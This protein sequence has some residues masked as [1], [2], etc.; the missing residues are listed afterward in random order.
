MVMQPGNNYQL[1]IE[2]I[3]LFIRRYY[4]NKL[5][6]GVILWAAVLL[7]GY[8]VAT[9]S[10]YFGHFTTFSRTVIFYSFIALNLA[11]IS[12]Y[13]LP[14]VFALLRLKE[15]ISHHQA[16]EI[17]G[18]HFGEIQD[19]LLNTLQLKEIADRD[20]RHAQLIQASIDQKIEVLRPV[21]FPTAVD[22]RQNVKYLKWVIPPALLILIIA[23]AAPKIL[24]DGT[25]RLVK[26]NQYFA[27][28]APFQFIIT[29][30]SLQATQ[31][32]DFK[33]D[34]K[35]QGNNFP[36]A[37]YIETE[38]H[39]FKLDKLS[40]SRFTYLFTNVQHTLAFKL[41]GGGYS[42]STYKLVVNAKP[43]LLH[44]NAALTYPAYLHKKN[45]VITNAGDLTIPVGTLVQ[46][47]LH[48]EHADQVIFKLNQQQKLLKPSQQDVFT[49]TERILNSG[50]YLLKPLNK[51]VINS[52]SAAYAIH[53]IADESPAIVAEEKQD[54]VS[55]KALYFNGKI[56]D[57]HGFSSLRF[58]YTVY[59]GDKKAGSY[60]MPVKADLTSTAA[61][62]F[63]FWNLK[64]LKAKPGNRISYYF[65]VVDNDAV[66]GPKTA[67]TNEKSLD[68]PTNQQIA[69]ELNAGTKEVQQKMQSAAKMAAKLEKETQ[70]LNQN[71]LNKRE[72]SFDEKK[73]VEDLL[74]KRKDLEEMLKNIRD[75]N[76]KNIY[77]RQQTQQQ[78]EQVTQLQKQ[79]DELLKN[80]LDPKTREMLERLKELL[81]TEQKTGT[82]EELNQM[83]NEN[84]SMK[85]ELER[86]AELYKKLDFEQK[87][88]QNVNK[89]NELA[90]K[91]QQLAEKSKQSD[92]A[93]R[94]QLN[95]QQQQLNKDFQEVKKG[96]N[97]LEKLAKENEQSQFSNPQQEE[98]QI[99]QKMNESAEQ[100]SKNN[101]KKAAQS[102]QQAAEAMQQLGRKL[103]QDNQ[104]QEGQQLSLNAQQLRELIKNLVNSSFDQ[105]KLMQTFRNTSPSD[106]NYT[107]LS[108]KQKDIKDNLKTAEDSLY[109]LSKKVPQIQS[110]VNDE[111][112]AINT[113]ISK[114]IDYLGDRRTMEA[115]RSQQYAMTS[116]NNLAL[117]LNEVLS[118]LQN[119]MKNAKGGKGKQQ[120]SMSQLSRM[121]QQLNNN[122]QKM[123]DQLQQ[124][125][126]QGQSQHQ[127]TS[128]QL[129]R[130]A[131]QQQ[132]IRRAIE[133]FNRE[134]LKDGK[135]NGGNLDKIAKQMEQT[136]N[137][138][139]NRRIT[140]ETIKR[141]QQIQTRLLEAEKAQQER[142]QDK[143]RLSQ[144]GKD[145]P[146]GYIKALQQ[147]QQQKVKQTEQLKTV[148]P[149]LNLYYKQKVKQYFNQ[150]NGK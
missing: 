16:A 1:L 91:Q 12:R 14:S 84:R 32:Q 149:E 82:R 43:S 6:R 44:F 85:K 61:D 142:E 11:I 23:F 126:N 95:Q 70:Q 22:I 7:T 10:E 39:T 117:M 78:D 131:R 135:G 72:L 31:G 50:T 18:Q 68:I 40:L 73:Q 123:R 93:N 62:F 98:Q 145:F 63:Y 88:N 30:P 15:T 103:Q 127:S 60:S 41:S 49:N 150:L 21:R 28:A 47:Q 5:L 17:I 101:N 54:S 37:L 113:Q 128:E 4:L 111:I 125:G 97:D 120:Q 92:A 51:Q 115:N 104:E 77:N 94:Q 146:P 147:Y 65:E 24:T 38:G 64:D 52:D 58:H 13:I 132:D 19:K 79:M 116:M 26:H 87:L 141:Q 29:N 3:D 96:L 45:E 67:R 86:M 109:A 130:M 138:I 134:Q 20:P 119:S 140:D 137:D 133:Q 107:R 55:M 66:K 124:Q 48:T 105:E 27:P 74:Q 90:E 71:L 76:Q 143:E 136:E 25:V 99:E 69:N 8:I 81:Q 83:Q 114:A 106:P 112:N 122:M 46:W 35:L 57:D 89:L 100:L 36:D 9:L 110:T 33:L 118:Q 108:Q 75:E 139:V 80:L 53:I 42:S 2:K 121:Q 56:Q 148:S 34:L 102:Q 129:A 144:S 59:D